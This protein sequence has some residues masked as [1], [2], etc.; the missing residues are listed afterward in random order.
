MKNYFNSYLIINSVSKLDNIIEETLEKI[1]QKNI[2]K[3]I[4]SYDFLDENIKKDTLNPLW[5]YLNIDYSEIIRVI[6]IKNVECCTNSIIQMFLKNIEFNKKNVIFFFTTK[7][8]DLILKTLN[9]RCII[10]NANESFKQIDNI[11]Q[12]LLKILFL[13][14][15]DIDS[16]D[17]F[18]EKNEP[19]EIFFI[20]FKPIFLQELIN[21]KIKNILEIKNFLNT[22]PITG[23]Y[24]NYL[25]ILYMLIDKNI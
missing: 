21:K 18:L 22:N 17:K 3:K 7:N 11:S 1:G 16:I 9:S 25:R 15:I 24:K 13:E 19:D 23:T 8:K 14:E 2:K 12:E 6:I 5:E 20:N 4:L 10:I